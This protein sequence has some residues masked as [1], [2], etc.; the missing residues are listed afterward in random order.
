MSSAFRYQKQKE[1]ESPLRFVCSLPGLVVVRRPGSARG[2]QVFRESAER[3]GGPRGRRRER[4][5][6]SAGATTTT[7]GAAAEAR[8]V[9]IGATHASAPPGASSSPTKATDATI[10]SN[11]EPRVVATSSS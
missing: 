3:P 11:A 5:S 9:D 4:P 7:G 6:G 1:H 8:D 10:K 2:W